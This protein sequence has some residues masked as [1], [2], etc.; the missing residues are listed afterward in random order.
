M[1]EKKRLDAEFIKKI[2]IILENKLIEY[3]DNV[4]YQTNNYIIYEKNYEI[5]EIGNFIETYNS[6]LYPKNINDSNKKLE[7]SYIEYSNILTIIQKKYLEN[8][9]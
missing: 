9:Y 8:K 3:I 5:S 1:I 6:I 2:G 7:N 4:M